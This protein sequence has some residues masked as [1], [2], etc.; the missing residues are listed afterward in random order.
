[1][2]HSTQSC[3]LFVE[4]LKI[5]QNVSEMNMSMLANELNI[6]IMN[7]GLAASVPSYI[8]A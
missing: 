6:Y 8:T 1:M 3:E 4:L 5:L 2:S 7:C